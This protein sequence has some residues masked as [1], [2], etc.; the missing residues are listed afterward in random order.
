[1]LGISFT[2]DKTQSKLKMHRIVRLT[3]AGRHAWVE[4][5]IGLVKK[6]LRTIPEKLIREYHAQNKNF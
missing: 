2:R 6:E 4:T 3:P 5:D 1:M